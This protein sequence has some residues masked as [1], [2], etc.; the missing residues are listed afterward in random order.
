MTD[1]DLYNLTMSSRLIPK[2]SNYADRPTGLIL[3]RYG[4]LAI[5]YV[6]LIFLLPGNKQVMQAH[7]LTTAEYHVLQLLVG[8][9]LLAIWFMG[10]YGYAKLGE[11]TRS[12]SKTPEAAGFRQLT[13]G[14]AWIAWSLPIH[15]IVALLARAVTNS[16]PGLSSAT[17][18]LSN[19]IDLLFPVVAFT[20]IGMASR[21][22]FDRTKIIL[23]AASIRGITLLFLAGGVLYCYL[24][25]QQFS[26]SLGS[27]G[28]PYHLPVWLMV[29]TVIVPYLYA[30]FVGM[31]A[32]YELIT[33]GR[34]VRGVLYRQ[35][36]HLL[37][38]GLF[39]VILGS[40]A[41]QYSRS[42]QPTT[43]HLVL[44]ANLLFSLIFQI[45]SGLGF[46]MIA[47]GAIRLK[48]I[49]EV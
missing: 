17:I 8:L 31:L 34:H 25:F 42:I 5:V 46:V 48:K 32:V 7:N 37:V 36:M 35:A 18:I 41:S 38:T 47:L 4:L 43:D 2:Y 27:T 6:L 20:L 44:G 22:L 24:V 11:Y 49:E 1:R 30:W 33:Y 15:S 19:Y 3:A 10:F 12:I 16:W 23:S 39:A 9:P 28:N 29:L 26:G 40:I 13:L 45:I 21:H 14:C